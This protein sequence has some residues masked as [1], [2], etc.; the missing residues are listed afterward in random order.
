MKTFEK[1]LFACFGGLIVYVIMMIGMS[2]MPQSRYFFDLPEELEQADETD[3]LV[4]I[5]KGRKITIQF[6]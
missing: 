2:S 3:T 6:Q 1:I 4:A 5:K